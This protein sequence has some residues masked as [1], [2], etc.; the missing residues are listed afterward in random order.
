MKRYGAESQWVLEFR[1][2]RPEDDI[3]D[4]FQE[5]R[6]VTLVYLL[7]AAAAKDTISRVGTLFVSL[8]CHM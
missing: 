1:P 8:A 3:Q 2:Q 5:V 6:T 4:Q 7:I